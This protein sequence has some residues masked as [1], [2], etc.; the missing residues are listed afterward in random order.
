MAKAQMKKNL[1]E[2]HSSADIEY[3]ADFF[4]QEFGKMSDQDMNSAFKQTADTEQS[5][6]NA[7]ADDAWKEIDEEYDGQLAVDV[8][9]TDAS[10]I[11]QSAV[12][13]V[14]IEDLDIAINGDMITIKGR[15]Q[16]QYGHIPSEKYFIEECYWGSFSRSII[17]PFDVLHDDISATL[18]NGILTIT[19][20]KA[21][22]SQHAK[23]SVK[24]LD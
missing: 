1:K 8:F 11:I 9:Q 21:K 7:P 17:L 14:N 4:A 6:W 13:G 24:Q 2:L 19:L 23:I 22:K 15:R 10:I 3:T 5:T 18:D 12:A 16:A 20:P